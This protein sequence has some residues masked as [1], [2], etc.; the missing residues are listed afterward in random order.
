MILINIKLN[1]IH[2]RLHGK[3]NCL[4][5]HKALISEDLI[6]TASLQFHVQFSYA[7]LRE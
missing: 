7:A 3:Q 6:A 5:R 2:S 4:Q 1:L